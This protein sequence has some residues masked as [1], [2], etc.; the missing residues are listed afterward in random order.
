[1]A[2]QRATI[3]KTKFIS[4]L[5]Q[6]KPCNI[7]KI[8]SICVEMKRKQWRGLTNNICIYI[9]QKHQSERLLIKWR[10]PDQ[11]ICAVKQH[12][13]TYG[14]SYWIFDYICRADIQPNMAQAET[15]IKIHNYS[16]R[17]TVRSYNYASPDVC[18]PKLW[19]SYCTRK[20]ANDLWRN[21]RRQT[22]RVSTYRVTLSTLR[23]LEPPLNLA[24]SICF[25]DLV[26]APS[27][28]M[29]MQLI[30]LYYKLWIV[31]RWMVVRFWM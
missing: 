28:A 31:L 29:F 15:E 7:P 24:T 5:D 4:V 9:L 20:W 11:S 14:E 22:R 12:W 27:V 21:S 10:L 18:M 19:L 30:D 26:T 17:R 13:W 6:I 23:E 25:K 1:M 16:R 3:Y 8:E 2:K